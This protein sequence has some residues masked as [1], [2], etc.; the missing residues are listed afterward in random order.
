MKKN[1]MVLLLCLWAGIT[2]AQSDSK[3]LY[4]N[5]AFGVQVPQFNEL[6][7]VLESAGYLPLQQVYFSRGGGFYTIFRKIPLATLFNLNSYTASQTESSKSNWVRA[8][9]AGTSLGLVLKRKKLQLIPYGGVIF[10]WFG[11]R[12][13]GNDPNGGTFNN[14]ITGPANQLHVSS[15]QFMANLGVHLA[16]TGFGNSK[17]GQNLVLGVRAGY[18]V[19]IGDQTW[20]TNTVTLSNGPEANPGSFYT[21]LIIGFAQ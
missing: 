14:Y 10:S 5:S 21:S 15:N 8:T 6:N 12:V 16:R 7:K 3:V 18:Y 17:L 11:V 1:S 13:S 20:K 4:L 19:P 9:Q 2:W